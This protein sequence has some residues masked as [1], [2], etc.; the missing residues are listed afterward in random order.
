MTLTASM[1]SQGQKVDFNR[2]LSHERV[3]LEECPVSHPE[4]ISQL[5]NIRELCAFLSSSVQ[6]FRVTITRVQNG[7]DVSLSDCIIHH[8]SLRQKVI[9]AALLYGMTRLFVDGEVLVEREKP[10]IY[11]GD[12]RVEFPSG[13]FLQATCEAENIMGNIILIHLKKV[14]NTL[15]LFAGVGTFTLRMAKKMNVHAVENDEKA[16]ENLNSAARFSTGLKTVICEKRDLFRHPLSVRELECFESVVLGPPR[17]G[18]EG[19]VRELAKATV[20]RVVAISCNP[21]TFAR[22]LSLLVVGGYTIEN[23]TPID[24]FLWS[25][26]IEVV[27]V[28]SKNKKK[29]GWKL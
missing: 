21:V 17:A 26:H 6:W 13:S 27:A 24:Q 4:L 18:A 3:V 16:L 15:D 19:Q 23:I 2:Y 12:V 10:V 7:L 29:K 8:E 11:F 20:S 22:D 25:S 28:L 14:K 5:R 1:T 9:N